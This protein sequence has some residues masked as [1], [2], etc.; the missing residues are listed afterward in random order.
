LVAAAVLI[1]GLVSARVRWWVRVEARLPRALREAAQVIRRVGSL[2][3]L[4]GPVLMVL[5]NWAAQWATYYLTLRAAHVSVGVDGAF[6]ALI[7]VNLV[8]LMQLPAG[9]LGVFQAS[10]AIG[11][12]PFGVPAEQAVAAG[13]ILQALQVLPVLGVA[14][15]L[16]GWRGFAQLRRGARTFDEAVPSA[17]VDSG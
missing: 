12:L 13:V 10:I 16:L 9:N 2:R 7:A 1:I 4:P 17:A 14:V 3:R 8:G 11:L 5:I 6:V 15:G